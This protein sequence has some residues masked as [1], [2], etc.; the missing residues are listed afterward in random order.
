MKQQLND[1]F[2]IHIPA[3]PFSSQSDRA[4]A[5]LS[6]D[7]KKIAETFAIVPNW[8]NI[9]ISFNSP[10]SK[11]KGFST[12]RS[13]II[14]YLKTPNKKNKTDIINLYKKLFGDNG[15]L[16]NGNYL[17]TLVQFWMSLNGMVIQMNKDKKQQQVVF[18]LHDA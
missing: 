7:T 17:F 11:N 3:N 9:K 8:N 4:L 16:F 15:E 6:N 10:T 12:F 13:F 18:R 1:L 2:T 5:S 14:E